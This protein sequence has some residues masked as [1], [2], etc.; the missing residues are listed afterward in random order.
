MIGIYVAQ[1][2]LFTIE[3]SVVAA[4]WTPLS[5]LGR[6]TKEKNLA[7]DM[8]CYRMPLVRIGEF[9]VGILLC[10]LFLESQER[11][12]Q[13]EGPQPAAK[14]L[15]LL[16]IAAVA[17]GAAASLANPGGLLGKAW[18]WLESF[19]LY[20]PMYCVIVFGLAKGAR[21]I[22][23]FLSHPLMQLLGDASYSLYLIHGTT[24][25]LALAFVA[26]GTVAATGVAIGCWLGCI[27]ASV[28]FYRYFETPVR[29]ALR[30]RFRSP[31]A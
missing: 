2:A 28:L 3:A 26:R 9:L 21:P 29:N 31:Q 11:R 22:S 24:L 16:V 13:S 19:P 30:N 10:L 27:I 5:L 15:S 12:P 1:S 14:S 23:G 25:L 17:Y 4:K 7:I 20:V 6:L 18:P 8:L